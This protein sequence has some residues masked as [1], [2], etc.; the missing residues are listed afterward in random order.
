MKWLRGKATSGELETPLVWA[1]TALAVCFAPHVLHFPFWITAATVAAGVWR[2]TAERRRW[3][4]PPLWLRALLVFAAL[5]GVLAL[6]AGIN[7]VVPGTALLALMAALKILESNQRR[8]LHVVLFIAL[9]LA[10]SSLLREQALWSLPYLAIALFACLVAWQQVAREGN[11]LPV[12]TVTHG[13][14]RIARHAAPLLIAFWILFP[15]VPGAFWAVPTQGEGASTGISDRIE[16][17]SIAALIASD[18]VAFRVEFTGALPPLREMYWRGPV[19]E[20]VVGRAWQ[21]SDFPPMN[22]RDNEVSYDGQPYRY[23]MTLQPTGQR[24]LFGLDVPE[25]WNHP[26]A[27]MSPTQQLMVRQPI[28]QRVVMELRSY[29]EFTIGGELSARTR[30][31]LTYLPGGSN[32]KTRELATT[33]R[34]A[35]TDEDDFVR[36]VLALFA[37]GDFVYTLEPPPLG[38]NSMDEFLFAT[39]AGFCEHYASAFATLMRAGGVPARLIGGYQGGEINPLGDYLIVRQSDAHA[40]VEIWAQERGWVRIDPT[41]AVSS[42]RLESGLDAA[43]R[44]S[45]QAGVGRW[46]DFDWLTQAGFTWDALNARWDEWVLGYGPETQQRFMRWLGMDDPH[47]EKLAMALGIAT[48]LILAA[49]ALRLAR[50]YAKPRA[51]EAR[52]VF[53]RVIRRLKVSLAPHETAP[54]A[55]DKIGARYPTLE[56][57]AARFVERYQAIRYAGDDSIDTLR[58]EATALITAAR[59]APATVTTPH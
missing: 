39:R 11:P 56:A 17:G 45:G 35:S 7:G 41:A 37:N 6:Y 3:H 42:V 28:D 14:S 13:A 34:D 30:K 19:M 48:A 26:N 2:F 51:D 1:T 25:T 23:R 15:R 36:Q 32:P 44:S 18:A 20:A 33:L 22:R 49:I 58:R 53:E 8:D 59:S 9:F 16:P 38:L 47:W 57:E 24:W 27:K 46:L 5:L 29:T 54:V 21:V 50:Q 31:R 43:L 52:R 55:A 12:S 4:L 40:W 10:L